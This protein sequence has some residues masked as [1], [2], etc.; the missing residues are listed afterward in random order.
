M[1][2]NENWD[3]IIK[4]E[5]ANMIDRLRNRGIDAD[6]FIVDIKGQNTIQESADCLEVDDIDKIIET[7]RRRN[8]AIKRCDCCNEI[9]PK[10]TTLV[11]GVSV[12]DSCKTALDKYISQITEVCSN[13]TRGESMLKCLEMVTKFLNDNLESPEDEPT[14]V[15]EFVYDDLLDFM[16]FDSKEDIVDFLNRVIE[17]IKSDNFEL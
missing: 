13:S 9:V 12:C 1:K 7:I 4:E 10:V 8:N 16:S 2:E 15:E 5:I 17:F 11:P 6:R 14:L 3:N